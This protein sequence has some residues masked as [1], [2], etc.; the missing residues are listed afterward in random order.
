MDLSVDMDTLD[1][2]E[3]TLFHHAAK[4]EDVEVIK[5]IL[6]TGLANQLNASNRGKIPLLKAITAENSDNVIVLVEHGADVNI[7]HSRTF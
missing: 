5:Y 2:E 3:P 7:L 4:K 1:S 6:Q